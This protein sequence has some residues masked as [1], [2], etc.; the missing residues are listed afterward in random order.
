MLGVAVGDAEGDVV[1]DL[2][3]KRVTAVERSSSSLPPRRRLSL[4]LLAAFKKLASD[5]MSSSCCADGDRLPW[6]KVLVE[7]RPPPAVAAMGE[8]QQEAI[9]D[10][11]RR[12]GTR[13]MIRTMIVCECCYARIVT[14][15]RAT[16]VTA[17]RIRMLAGVRCADQGRESV[18]VMRRRGSVW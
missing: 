17:I 4:L 12:R 13:P 2:V 9:V 14:P 8:L 18:L 16:G 15:P 7:R 11:S 10:R 3:G 1:G 5:F 6:P